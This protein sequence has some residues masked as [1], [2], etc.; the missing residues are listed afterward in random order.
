[1]SLAIE[2]EGRKCREIGHMLHVWSKLWAERKGET[3]TAAA[4]VLFKCA[5]ELDFRNA[6][7]LA[8]CI[9]ERALLSKEMQDNEN[10]VGGDVRP[11]LSS[12]SFCS[13]R[14]SFGLRCGAQDAVAA[15]IASGAA[16][17]TCH[18][19]APVDPLS[20]SHFMP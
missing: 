6:K 16:L 8:K 10:K 12:Q 4:C 18:S 5:T 15:R 14:A 19:T 3:R 13:L 7:S 2:S 11:L 9:N 17:V 1:M 20:R